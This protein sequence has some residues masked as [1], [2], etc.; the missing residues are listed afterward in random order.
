MNLSTNNIIKY[1]AI[2]LLLLFVIHFIYQC[3]HKVTN[4]IVNGQNTQSTIKGKLKDS[5][6]Y[7]AQIVLLAETQSQVDLL[8]NKLQEELFRKIN[9]NKQMAVI[10]FKDSI[11]YIKLPG[12]PVPHT[13]SE[14]SHTE[15]ATKFPLHFKHENSFINESYT[16]HS[17]DSAV[18]D[19]LRIMGKT[20]L[21]IGE[22]G[23]WYQKKTIKIGVT[24]ENPYFII[25]SLQSVLYSPKVSKFSLVVGPTIYY[26]FKS[27][28]PKAQ[29]GLT[30]GYRI[31]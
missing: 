28:T 21:V 9:I 13:D 15:L 18:I 25:D 26:D 16:V 23:K 12:V 19:E 7:A 11:V 2:A 6:N 1:V 8:K 29:I 24:N 10:Q 20:N 30:L 4:P 22:S 3:N 27:R 14:P 5:L 31:F 17:P